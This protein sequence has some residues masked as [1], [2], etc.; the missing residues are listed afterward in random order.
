VCGENAEIHHE[1]VV[2]MGRNRKTINHLGM[3]VIALCRVHHTE[4]HSSGKTPF[5]ERYHVYG[6][7]ADVPI[8]EKWGLPSKNGNG[9]VVA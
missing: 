1:D 3:R 6:I 2:G 9:D 7:E 4:A 8:C 5:N